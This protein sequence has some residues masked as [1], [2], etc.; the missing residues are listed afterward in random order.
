MLSLKYIFIKKSLNSPIFFYN[1]WLFFSFVLLVAAFLKNIIVLFKNMCCWTIILRI[2][3]NVQFLI[4]ST[5]PPWVHLQIL[6][7]ESRP[8]LPPELSDEF[9]YVNPVYYHP[10]P[11]LNT[12]FHM[13][14]PSNLPPMNFLS[15]SHVLCSY[16]L[17]AKLLYN[18][19][20]STVHQLRLKENVIF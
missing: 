13:W 2:L 6:I 3:R 12:S 15:S 16:L 14:I 10:P 1:I 11:P 7:C 5:Q 9:P 8:T 19:K 4:P 18:K 20:L 17:A